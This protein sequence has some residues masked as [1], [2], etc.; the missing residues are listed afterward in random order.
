MT[1][2]FDQMKQNVIKD[3][4]GRNGNGKGSPIFRLLEADPQTNDAL[5]GTLE[6]ISQRMPGMIEDIVR[7]YRRLMGLDPEKHDSKPASSQP[8]HPEAPSA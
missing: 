1:L 7:K 6:S 4:T 8:S 5:L 3:L 2:E